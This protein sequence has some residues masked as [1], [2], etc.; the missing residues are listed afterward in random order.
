[1]AVLDGVERDLLILGKR[2]SPEKQ[3]NRRLEP[4]AE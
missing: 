4:T 3:P 1:V 2:V